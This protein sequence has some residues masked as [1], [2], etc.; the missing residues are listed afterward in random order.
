MLDCAQT[1]A[2]GR[3]RVVPIAGVTVAMVTGLRPAGLSGG[4]YLK[5]SNLFN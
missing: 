3:S 4:N 2:G 1:V 5:L